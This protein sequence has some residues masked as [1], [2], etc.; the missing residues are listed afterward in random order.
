MACEKVAQISEPIQGNDPPAF[1]FSAHLLLRRI[2]KLTS[3][4]SNK[5]SSGVVVFYWLQV[6]PTKFVPTFLTCHMIAAIILL[7]DDPAVWAMLTS[8]GN[9]PCFKEPLFVAF[10]TLVQMCGHLATVH[11][12]FSATL[13]TSLRLLFALPSYILFTICS[14]TPAEVG[15]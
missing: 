11:T 4:A 15:I 10:S 9:F 5:A 6:V 2:V 7:Y 8:L 1:K 14:W 12:N 3:Y 13:A